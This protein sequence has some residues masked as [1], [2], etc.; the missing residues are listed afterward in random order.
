MQAETRLDASYISKADCIIS[1]ETVLLILAS[2]AFESNVKL[3]LPFI[4]CHA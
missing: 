4:F 2:P 3:F 1:D